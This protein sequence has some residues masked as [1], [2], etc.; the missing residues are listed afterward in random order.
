MLKVIVFKNFVHFKNKTV[1]SFDAPKKERAGNSK[2]DGKQTTGLNFLNIFVGASFS[3]KS[4][5]LELIRR[6]MTKRKNASE[7]SSCNEGRIAYAFCKFDLAPDDQIISGIIKK[8][9][10]NVVYKILACTKTPET[11]TKTK[12]EIIAETKV[13]AS[14]DFTDFYSC[15]SSVFADISAI[16][17]KEDNCDD[18]NDEKKLLKAI[19]N[20]CKNNE[21]KRII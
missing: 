3:G 8:Q 18:D 9:N 17:N 6:C 21:K 12:E 20:E 14:S 13:Y 15:K 1:I 5:V 10:T 16:L 19:E 2:G 4:T 11:K 7:T